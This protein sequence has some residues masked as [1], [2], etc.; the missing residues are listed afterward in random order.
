MTVQ[1]NIIGRIF[2]LQTWN[3]RSLFVG[4]LLLL[5]WIG[6]WFLTVVFL[7]PYSTSGF[8]NLGQIF[9]LSP[10]IPIYALNMLIVSLC[11]KIISASNAVKGGLRIAIGFHLL[12]IHTYYLV[13]TEPWCEGIGC[14]YGEF[15]A[16]SDPIFF[17]FIGA[18]ALLF[19]GIGLINV[20]PKE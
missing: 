4:M 3:A 5:S 18:C 2:E 20:W 7:S 17:I 10:G 13:T 16:A 1:Q 15:M 12:V 14:P 19:I 11:T 6:L 8:M 9:L